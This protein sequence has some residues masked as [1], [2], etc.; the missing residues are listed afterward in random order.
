MLRRSHLKASKSGLIQ[1]DY[2]TI[3]KPL[4]PGVSITAIFKNEANYL[5]EWVEYHLIVGVS[6]F[7]LYDNGSDD[8]PHQILKPYITAGN[9]SVIPWA[10]FEMAH[11]IQRFAYRHA[12]VNFGAQYQWMAFIDLDEFIVPNHDIDL[13]EFLSKHSQYAVVKMPMIDFGHNGHSQ[14]PDGLVTENYIKGFYFGKGSRVKSIIQPRLVDTIGTHQSHTRNPVLAIKE[15]PQEE[16]PL[17][18]NHYYCKSIAEYNE[19]RSKG[20]AQGTINDLKQ[21]DRIF[22][23]INQNCVKQSAIEPFLPE[24]RKRVFDDT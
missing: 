20:W 18:I 22:E 19:K 7:Y 12:A 9:V 11:N 3:R 1:P 15:M 2:S 10:N 23:T 16:W 5:R 14:K 8:Y 4:Q 6:H 17:R 13:T 24:L 21:K